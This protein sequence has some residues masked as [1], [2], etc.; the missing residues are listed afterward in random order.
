MGLVVSVRN[1][2]DDTIWTEVDL[3]LDDAWRYQKRRTVRAGDTVTAPLEDFR[4]DD[5]PPPPDYKP[6]KL[7]V[8]CQQGRV[9]LS[10]VEKR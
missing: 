6:R 7:S 3:V 8:Q 1:E 9:A 4:R 2:S 5:L 10:L